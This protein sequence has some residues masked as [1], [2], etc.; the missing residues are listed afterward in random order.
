M[1]LCISFIFWYFDIFFILGIRINILIIL[2]DFLLRL[3]DLGNGF[4][5]LDI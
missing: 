3:L 2:E 5:F 4:M 1:Y